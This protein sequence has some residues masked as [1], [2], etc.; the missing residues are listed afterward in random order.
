MTGL[1]L[2][3]QKSPEHTSAQGIFSFKAGYTR[4]AKCSMQPSLFFRVKAYRSCTLIRADEQ[5]A[6]LYAVNAFW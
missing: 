1:I 4:Y 5:A 2:R 6:S 3:S